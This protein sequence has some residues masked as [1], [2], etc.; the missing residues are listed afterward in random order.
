MTIILELS[1]AFSKIQD[2]PVDIDADEYGYQS[3]SDLE[4]DWNLDDIRSPTSTSSGSKKGK[5]SS[6][7]R[8]SDSLSLGTFNLASQLKAEDTDSAEDANVEC[9]VPKAS[10]CVEHTVLITDIAA[11]TFVAFD[12]ANMCMC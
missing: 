2:I 11:N 10:S 3:D 8:S 4:D 9:D 6:S 1:A 7:K 12:Y 5:V